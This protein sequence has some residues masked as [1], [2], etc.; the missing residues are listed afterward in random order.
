MVNLRFFVEEFVPFPLWADGADP[1]ELR[2]QLPMSWELREDLVRLS[3]DFNDR[4]LTVFSGEESAQWN[5]AF[6][7]RSFE[8]FRRVQDELPDFS[9]EFKPRTTEFGARLRRARGR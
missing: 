3:R 1:E 6:D 7:E 9:V 2:D 4:N 5:L 8:L